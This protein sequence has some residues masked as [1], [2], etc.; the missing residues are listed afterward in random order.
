LRKR[1]SIININDSIGEGI[2]GY[3]WGGDK[4]MWETGC[5]QK[6]YMPINV[7]APDGHFYNY[8]CEL[9]G[10]SEDVQLDNTQNIMII[11]FAEVLLMGAELGS[12]HAQQYLDM[13][14]NR[15]GLP[16]VPVTL[17]N[18]Q[19]E[20][21]HEFVFE[22]IRYWDELRWGTLISDLQVGSEQTVVNAGVTATYSTATAINRFGKT[23]GFLPIPQQEISL[24]AGELD[25]NDGWNDADAVYPN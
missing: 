12:S 18:I 24:S 4:Q 5:W 6:K 8:S 20:R 21:K 3:T 2:S 14:R 13:V 19:E 11:R 9:N 22:N 1:G 10:T 17:A 16:S 15:V 7:V 25:Q 23:K